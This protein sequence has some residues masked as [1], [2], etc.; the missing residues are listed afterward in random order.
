MRAAAPFRPLIAA[1]VVACTAA[2]AADDRAADTGRLEPG[3]WRTVETRAGDTVVVRTVG[4]PDSATLRLVAELRIGELDGGEEYGFGQVAAIAPA[5]AGGVYVLDDLVK[6]IRRYDSAGRYVRQ[7]GRRGRGPGEHENVA[8]MHAVGD[9]LLFW[10][11]HNQHVSVY[12]SA[13]TLAHRWQPAFPDAPTGELYAGTGGRVYLRHHIARPPA[14]DDHAR[15][16]TGYVSYDVRGGAG[17]DTVP[18]VLVPDDQPM[19]RAEGATVPIGDA[20]RAD[21]EARIEAG[22][23]ALDAGWRWSGDRIPDHKPHFRTVRFDAD[24]RLWVERAMAGTRIPDADVPAPP[25]RTGPLGSFPPRR[26]REPLAYDLFEP[27]GRFLGTV[28]RPDGATFLYM[29]GDT[30]WGVVRDALDVPYVT[31]WRLEPSIVR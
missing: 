13:G 12:D 14:G 9:A 15:T 10:D 21:E 5:P 11:R 3:G 25:A 28:A 20:E 22:M 1:G 29:R 16:R 27:D 24:G 26:W 18:R 30:V 6:S 7:V 17:P 8:G 4:A 23:R 2:C 19:L 31:R